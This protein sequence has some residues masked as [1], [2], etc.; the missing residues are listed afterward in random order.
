M[1]RCGETITVF[2]DENYFQFLI[3]NTLKR[4]LYMYMKS[5]TLKIQEY[6]LWTQQP[7]SAILGYFLNT[8]YTHYKV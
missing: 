8:I 5:F 4:V 7:I 6:C 2:S 1:A 3:F